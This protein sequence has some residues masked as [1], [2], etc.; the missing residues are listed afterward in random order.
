MLSSHS[1]SP[2]RM[3]TAHRLFCVPASR[4]MF[5]CRSCISAVAPAMPESSVVH[6]PDRAAQPYRKGSTAASVV[7]ANAA[8]PCSARRI[9][10]TAVSMVTPYR[11]TGTCSAFAGPLTACCSA[12]A[13]VCTAGA[14]AVGVVCPTATAC[15]AANAAHTSN[16]STLQRF[17]I[18]LLYTNLFIKIY[19]SITVRSRELKRNR[20]QLIM[21]ATFTVLQGDR[22][23]ILHKRL[24]LHLHKPLASF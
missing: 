10:P 14:C 4:A 6:P 9:A 7:H 17:F 11:S 22:Y 19:N 1:A 15:A 20:P 5:P 18:T 12:A 3:P 8:L 24:E 23:K 21:D 13:V 16:N 2:A